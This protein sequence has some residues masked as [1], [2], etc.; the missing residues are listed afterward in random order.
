[1]P[2]DLSAAQLDREIDPILA[3]TLE[4]VLARRDEAAPGPGGAGEGRPEPVWAGQI[5]SETGATG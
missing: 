2:V 3:D 1:M 5:D 4:E